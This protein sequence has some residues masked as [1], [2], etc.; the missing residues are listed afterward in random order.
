MTVCKY[1]YVYVYVYVCACVYVFANILN[2][3]KNFQ[4]HS[5]NKKIQKIIKKYFWIR[6][7]LFLH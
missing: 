4:N 5:K 2:F 3:L 7:T 1:I 6:N